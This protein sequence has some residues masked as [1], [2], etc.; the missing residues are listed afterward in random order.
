MREKGKK[1]AKKKYKGSAGYLKKG[2][3]KKKGKGK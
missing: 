1:T 3:K 2:L